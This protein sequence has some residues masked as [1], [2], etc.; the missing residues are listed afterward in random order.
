MIRPFEAKDAERIREIHAT[1]NLP[2]ECLP[3]LSDPLILHTGIVE[4][5]GRATIA[6]ALKGT[7][8]LYLFVDHSAG[9]PEER[10]QWMLELR[11]YMIRQAWRLGLDQMSAW[12]PPEIE[13]SFG[14]R[15][16]EMGFQKSP[17][18]C[19]TLQLEK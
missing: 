9:T 12:I 4:I 16:E 13:E 5:E 14:K 2:A 19:Y 11:E 15:L 6:C 17:W 1:N 7:C 3:D 10:W 18:S 8:E